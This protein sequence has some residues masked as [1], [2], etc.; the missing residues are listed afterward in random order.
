M[1]SFFVR[2]PSKENSAKIRALNET[3]LRIN[4]QNEEL[5][6]ENKA[7]REDL[8]REIEGKDRKFA[9]KNPHQHTFTCFQ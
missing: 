3:I 7:L 8:N 2:T 4:K 6:M 9:G 1:Y 5:Q